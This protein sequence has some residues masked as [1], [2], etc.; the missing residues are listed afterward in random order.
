MERLVDRMQNLPYHQFIGIKIVSWGEGL[1]QISFPASKNNLNPYGAMHGGIYCETPIP[2]AQRGGIGKLNNPAQR[3]VMR[4][5]LQKRSVLKFVSRIILHK[6]GIIPRS[7]LRNV[8][9]ACFG[10]HTR[11]FKTSPYSEGLF[12]YQGW[13]CS[14]RLP[15]AYYHG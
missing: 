11:D 6:Q 9:K 3:R 8:S 5:K 15:F 14:I 12:L 4:L 7:L 13:P 1:S 2:K 10:V